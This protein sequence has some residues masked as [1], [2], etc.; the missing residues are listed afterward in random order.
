MNLDVRANSRSAITL[1]VLAAIFLAAIVWAWAKVTAPFPEKVVPAACNDTLI[2]AGDEL[3]PPQVLVT[4]LNAGGANGLA[5][6]TM[7]RL[8]GFGFAEGKKGNLSV[9]GGPI[10]AQVWAKN[11]KDPAAILL[12]SYLG[13]GTQIVDKASAY[14]GIT[15]VVGKRF[16]GVKQGRKTVTAQQDS[17]VCTP[18]LSSQPDAG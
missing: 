10:A 15:I 7:T 4:V 8:T 11:P 6:K 1:A 18:P 13:K 5:G 3:A 12:A 9:D 17:Y 14:P 16:Q 2:A